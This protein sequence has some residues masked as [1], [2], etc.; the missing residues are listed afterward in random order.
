MRPVRIALVLLAVVMAWP[1]SA[2]FRAADL[3][4]VPVAASTVGLQNSN[5]HSDIEIRNVDTVPIDVEIIFLPTGGSDN[6]YWYTL[7]ANALGGRES[8]GFGHVNA[9]LKDIPAGRTVVIEDIVKTTWGDGYKGAL[10]IFA[11][12]AGSFSTTTPPGGTPRKIVVT[13]TTYNLATNAENKPVTYGQGIPGLPWYDYIDPHQQAKGL[14]KVTFTGIREDDR[15]RTAL[16]LVNV[17]DQLTSLEIEMV[18][19]GADG[20]ELKDI[21]TVIAPLSHQQFDQVVRTVFGIASDQTITNATLTVRIKA[22]NSRAADPTPALIAYCSRV[23]NL[24]NDPVY[25]E[26]AFDA[27]LPWDCVFNGNCTALTALQSL[28]APFR[29]RPLQPITRESKHMW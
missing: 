22:W 15:Y 21:G 19:T 26:Q 24:T 13:S 14:D 25:L 7:M 2:V 5:W 3:V 29:R 20:T 17:S 27:E 16:G 4:I 10:L 6:S 9:A 1:A 23:D 12:D 8:D 11:Y 28:A 18:L